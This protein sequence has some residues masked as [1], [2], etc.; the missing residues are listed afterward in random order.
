MESSVNNYD[1][2]LEKHIRGLETSAIMTMKNPERLKHWIDTMLKF[3]QYG[4]FN[5]MKLHSAY[6]NPTYVKTLKSWNDMGVLV[7]KG[8]HGC[9]LF[10]PIII[11]G[12]EKNGK[13]IS[14]CKLSQEER[15]EIK[16]KRIPLKKKFTG[17]YSY[18]TAFDISQTN[19]DE[20]V[21]AELANKK[22]IPNYNVIQVLQNYTSSTSTDLNALS[23]E[24]VKDIFTEKE[25]HE[26]ADIN[27]VISATQLGLLHYLGEN[28]EYLHFQEANILCAEKYLELSKEIYKKIKMVIKTINPFLNN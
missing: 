28:T 25:I 1:K 17:R 3:T 27:Y 15:D 4:F 10:R 11:Q 9:K 13:F 20:T 12:I 5:Q 7:K 23:M 8:E 26:C 2:K 14:L 18:F 22:E 24:V 21:L 19:A 6:E 16:K